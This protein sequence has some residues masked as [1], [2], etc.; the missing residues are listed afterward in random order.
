MG[1]KSLKGSFIVIAAAI[2]MQAGVLLL[3]T[4]F[5]RVLQNAQSTYLAILSSQRKF[6]ETVSVESGIAKNGV[7]EA[8]LKKSYEALSQL[9]RSSGLV[10]VDALV[11]KRRAL[12]DEYVLLANERLQLHQRI[13]GLLPELTSSV[14]HIH[15]QHIG[16][17]KKIISRGKSFQ[18]EEIG[19]APEQSPV[20]SATGLDIIQ[21]AVSVQTRLLDVFETFSKIER[22]FSPSAVSAEFEKRIQ[23][24]YG[25]VNTFER[26]PLDAQNG[27]LVEKLLLNGRTFED[28]FNRFL[29]I[30]KRIQNLTDAI[31]NNQGFLMKRLLEAGDRIE[32]TYRDKQQQIEFL[33][34]I[35]LLVNVGLFVLLF[36]YGKRIVQGFR[37]T[38]QETGK[39]QQDLGYRIQIRENDFNELRIVFGGLNAMAETIDSQFHELQKTR[40]QLEE[41][42]RQRTAELSKANEKLIDEIEDRIRSEKERLQLESKL[43]RAQKMEA[44]GTLAGGVAHDLNNILS[45]IVSYPELILMDLPREDPL[46][47]PILTIK[48]SGEK[49]VAI[50]QDLLTLARRG[51]STQE[52]VDL[53]VLVRDFIRSPECE[54][55]LYD[56][57]DVTIERCLSGDLGPMVGSRVHLFKTIMNLVS[58]AAEAMPGGGPVTI[59]TANQ[60]IDTTIRGYDDVKEGEYL[61]LSVGDAGVGIPS[62][63]LERIFEPFFTRKEMGRSGTGLGM[64]VVWGTVKDHAGYI[65]VESAL[66]QGTTF[67]LYFPMTRSATAKLADSISMEDYMGKGETV[68]VVD[69]VPEQRDI[70]ARMLKRLGYKV[71][72]V[73]SGEAAVTH[74][75]KQSVDIVLLDM[76]MPQG[77]DGLE[78]YREILDIHPEQKVVIAS[79]FSE[80]DRVTEAQRLGAGPYVK[81]PYSIEKIGLAIRN[82]LD[83]VV[84]ADPV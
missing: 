19:A 3:N 34:Y 1:L 80:T 35:S 75:R 55:I 9:L 84:P 62:G 53:N 30:E 41:R 24:L 68:L 59:V 23:G 36:I 60:Y 40:D 21:S 45:G 69:D 31:T 10:A 42:V 78:T 65:D 28:G 46:R 72:T 57:P 4:Y 83:R 11:D 77:M 20:S 67:T 7:S 79:G 82:E 38:V 17:M 63:D 16:Y 12:F 26:F 58:N 54:K 25:S 22:G 81:K 6:L 74:I 39:I 2:L 64:A 48:S 71:E 73:P 5:G 15:E 52:P 14:R 50:V 37:R 76:I 33:Q 66:N 18:R 13:N 43:N 29:L 61:K 51:V 44:I 8:P 49:A 47:S 70:A 27:L 56:H 32:S